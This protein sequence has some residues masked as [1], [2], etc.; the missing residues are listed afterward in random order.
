[1]DRDPLPLSQLIQVL[2]CP[3]QARELPEAAW[4]DL[5]QLG[6]HNQLLGQIAARLSA[7]GVLGNIPSSIARHFELALL[8]AGRR[9]ESALWEIRVLREALHETSRIL[10]LKGCAYLA[11]D[12]PGSR[13]RLFSDIDILVPREKLGCV[14]ARLIPHGW[15]PSR[16]SA[17]DSRYYREWMH[18]IPPMEHVRRHTVL[19]LHHAI[20]PPVS[21]YFIR[22]ERL[23]EHAVEVSPGIDVLSPADRTIHC[24]IHMFLEGEPRKLLRELYDLFSLLEFHF[25]S[26]AARERLHHRAADL[27]VQPLVEVA[28]GV[29]L[30]IFGDPE[31]AP[32]A[33]RRSDWLGACLAASARR[34]AGGAAHRMLSDSVLL[35][36][37]HWIKMPPWLL[38]THLT[39]KFVL[40]LLGKDKG[41]E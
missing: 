1:M 32:M 39:R 19:D 18:E 27:G 23:L 29:A 11:C 35:A 37:S 8:T 3:E 13:G 36:Y 24:A 38:T 31:D 10:L 6:L 30:R 21:R 16:V 41:P 25:G 17:Y 2:R 20:V 5:L 9:G 26:A 28:T 4:N 22:T 12:D 40:S 7:A 15:K 33:N 34:D 14:E